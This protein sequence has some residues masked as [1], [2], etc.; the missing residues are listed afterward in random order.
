[1]PDECLDATHTK[2][3]SIDMSLRSLFANGETYEI[4]YCLI[5][6]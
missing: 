1:M 6:V 3:G 2:I 4:K 5:S